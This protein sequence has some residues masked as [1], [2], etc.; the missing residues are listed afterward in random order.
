MELGTGQQS[1]ETRV[2]WLPDGR[3]FLR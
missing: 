1:E 2:M 3:K